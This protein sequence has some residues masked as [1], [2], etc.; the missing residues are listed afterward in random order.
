MEVLLKNILI[1]ANVNFGVTTGS[2]VDLSCTSL[3]LFLVS[4]P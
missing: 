2:E 1:G 3:Y 4:V